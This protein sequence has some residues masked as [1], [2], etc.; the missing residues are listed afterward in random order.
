MRGS[1]AESAPFREPP[2][3]GPR[4]AQLEVCPKSRSQA[5]SVGSERKN[6]TFRLK[7]TNVR[8]ALKRHPCRFAQADSLAKPS[9]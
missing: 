2:S 4:K 6:L 3:G 1:Q 5:R 8:P 9:K 7:V